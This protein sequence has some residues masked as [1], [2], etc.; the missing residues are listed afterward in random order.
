[1][2]QPITYYDV[3]S[4]HLRGPAALNTAS[5]WFARQRLISRR[6]ASF[7]LL[8]A[9]SPGRDRAANIAAHGRLC[10]AVASA[11]LTRL[12]LDG[13]WTR[14]TGEGAQ[15]V[16]QTAVYLFVIGAQACEAARLNRRWGG[17]D[18]YL[19]S[20]PELG[21]RVVI[22]RP[23]NR[24]ELLGRF[25]PNRISEAVQATRDETWHFEGFRY[26]PES[27]AG[28]MAEFAL[29]RDQEPSET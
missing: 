29:L 1:M 18:V 26:R 21:G 13:R 28:R 17:A 10:R 19:R 16:H 25:V 12:R 22:V 6:Q 5:L 20:G 27:W 11:G 23:P 7:C 8:T 14:R 24:T 15:R 9:W 3:L 2:N 4:A